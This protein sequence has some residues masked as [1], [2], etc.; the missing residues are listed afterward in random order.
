MQELSEEGRERRMHYY[1]Y[2]N[3]WSGTGNRWNRPNTGH[4]YNKWG[5]Q[6]WGPPPCNRSGKKGGCGYYGGNN[7]W[8]PCNR[9]GKKGGCGGY[10]GKKG[11]GYYGGY[12][13][14]GPYNNRYYNRGYRNGFLNYGGWWW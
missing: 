14:D 1:G 10:G 5:N 3:R 11:G 2:H 12:S 9:S 13:Y 7:N 4:N 6:R 8:G